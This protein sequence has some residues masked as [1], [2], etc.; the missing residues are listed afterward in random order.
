M[1]RLP[2]IKSN[3]LQKIKANLGAYVNN[4]KEDSSSW[5][6]DELGPNVFAESK[7]DMPEIHLTVDPANSSASD[8]DCVQILYG[9]LRNISNAQASDERLWAGLALGPFWNYVQDRWN[10]KNNC[11]KVSIEQHYFFAL[12]PRRSLTRN[13]ISRLWWIG[14]LT[15]DSKAQ[16]PWELTKFVCR[17]SRFIVDILE[18]SMSNNPSI[19]QPFIRAVMEAEKEGITIST[20]RIRE[21]AIY[22]DELGGIYILDCLPKNTIYKKILH[23]A[24][25]LQK[26]EDAGN[27]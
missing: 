24:E 10:I 4:F 2:F 26:K 17:Y 19:V 14:R 27:R 15:Y 20:Q 3:D 23:K 25:E 16:D 12:G 18:R 1:K 13:A 7:L 9:K 8:A 6:K 22:F 11:T 5:L 21:L